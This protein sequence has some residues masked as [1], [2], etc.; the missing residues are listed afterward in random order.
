[1][2]NISTRKLLRNFLLLS[3]FIIS[4]SFQNQV[5]AQD[6]EKSEHEILI[7]QKH[8]TQETE[9]S[10]NKTHSEES[11]HSSNMSPLFFIIIALIIGAGPRHFLKKSPLP[12]T[13]SLLL[14][15]LG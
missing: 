1:M 3:F 7:Q 6:H 13:V 4:I 9:I 15:G 5:I 8:N 2:L 11:K 12:F 14:I 10:D